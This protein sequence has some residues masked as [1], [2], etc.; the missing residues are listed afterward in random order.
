MATNKELLLEWSP[1]FAAVP[2]APAA[3]AAS[4]P[5]AKAASPAATATAPAPAGAQQ[6]DAPQPPRTAAVYLVQYYVS[7]WGSFLTSWS[8]VETALG[9][10]A[11]AATLPGGAEAAAAAAAAAAS[12]SA[13]GAVAAPASAAGSTRTLVGAP[14]LVTDSASPAASSRSL[15]GCT[16]GNGVGISDAEVASASL[17][18]GITTSPLVVVRGLVPSTGYVLRV[19]PGLLTI[20]APAAADGQSPAAAKPTAPAGPRPGVTVTWGTPSPATPVYFT[21]SDAGEADRLAALKKAEEE[22]AKDA[23][24]RGQPACSPCPTQSPCRFVLPGH[25]SPWQR[26]QRTH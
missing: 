8:P 26:S 12:S 11:A 13:P 16:R 14:P 22:R 10:E 7:A 21:L 25:P 6:P 19:T 17:G 4:G 15:H 1:T 23:A 2:T 24:V 18:P 5:L 9:G 20:A 3:A